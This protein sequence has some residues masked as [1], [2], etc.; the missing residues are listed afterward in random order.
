MEVMT[1]DERRKFK[2]L[3]DEYG[4]LDNRDELELAIVEGIEEVDDDVI[5]RAFI[6]VMEG[7][8]QELKG[9]TG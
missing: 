9:E 8:N 7:F 4:I 1:A 6:V 5:R 2:K 3:L